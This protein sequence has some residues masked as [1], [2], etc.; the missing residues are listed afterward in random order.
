MFS[1]DFLYLSLTVS[2]PSTL[3]C[4]PGGIVLVKAMQIAKRQQFLKSYKD[5]KPDVIFISRNT[6]EKLPSE[7]S[8]KLPLNFKTENKPDKIRSV[9]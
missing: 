2:H 6:H 1:F 8:R 5:M 7:C 3:P 9:I 4:L